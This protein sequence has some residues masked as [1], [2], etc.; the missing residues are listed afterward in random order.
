MKPLFTPLLAAAVL[1]LGALAAPAALAAEHKV[2]LQVSENDE[3]KWNLAL[4]NAKNLQAAFGKDNVEIEIVVFG[5]G[6]GMLKAESTVG[7][8]VI[9]A[10]AGGVRLI[11]CENTMK[12]QKL[13]RDD[14]LDG[15]A[16][17]PAGVAEI[18]LRQKQGWAYI[19][20]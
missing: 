13:Q 5:P 17:V 4:N 20:P 10:G 14:M 18:T 3:A 7:N 1:G 6:I 19:R 16:Y 2:M 8:R 9:D 12:A 15:V 11:A